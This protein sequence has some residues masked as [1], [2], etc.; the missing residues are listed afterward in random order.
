MSH[1]ELV[2]SYLE[3]ALF[4][5]KSLPVIIKEWSILGILFQAQI[6]MS[7]LLSQEPTERASVSLKCWTD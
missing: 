3:G 5:L 2:L 4:V 7:V 1:L 6:L